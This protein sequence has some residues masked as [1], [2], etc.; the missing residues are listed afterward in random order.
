MASQEGNSPKFEKVVFPEHGLFTVSL[1]GLQIVGASAQDWDQYISELKKVKDQAIIVSPEIMTFAGKPL[2]SAKDNR[3][4]IEERVR[5]VMSI[6]LDHR[7]KKYILGTLAF[8]HEKPVNA[9]VIIEN[10][11]VIDRVNKR[12]ATTVE[13]NEF[14]LDQNQDPS[15]IPNTSIGLLICS[16]LQNSYSPQ[17][18]TGKL[19]PFVHPDARTLILMSCW[20]VGGIEEEIK[21]IGADKYYEIALNWYVGIFF[22][23][24]KNIEKLLVVDR[25]PSATR[26]ELTPSKPFNSLF[27]RI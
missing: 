10:G 19:K 22:S 18:T 6:S 24:F 25:V 23:V 5:Q 17:I 20:G 9:A 26:R 16:D 12:S 2:I 3:R 1:N 11:R 13:F 15:L 8:D 27:S 4:L 14:Y 21:N 7:N